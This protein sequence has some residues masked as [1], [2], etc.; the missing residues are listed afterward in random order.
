MWWVVLEMA[1]GEPVRVPPVG[2]L[3]LEWLVPVP[4]VEWVLA[5]LQEQAL[6]EWV[7]PH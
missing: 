1:L 2:W 5:A 3:G 7:P 4:S 6:P